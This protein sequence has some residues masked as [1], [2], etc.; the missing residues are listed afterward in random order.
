MDDLFFVLA[1][2]GAGATR[3][4]IISHPGP[5]LPTLVTHQKRR[6]FVLRPERASDGR[7]ETA[8]Q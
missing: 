6:V 4:K 3:S 7:K 8:F 1:V 2:V 5:E